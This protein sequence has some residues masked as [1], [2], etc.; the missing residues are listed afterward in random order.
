MKIHP[1]GRVLFLASLI[2]SFLPLHALIPVESP[3]LSVDEK[4]YGIRT[5]NGH[6]ESIQELNVRIVS[7]THSDHPFVVECFFLK[8]GKTGHPPLVDDTV[9]FEVTDPHATFEIQAKPIGLATTASTTTSK[10][11]GKSSM[12]KPK[13]LE[14]PREGWIIRLLQNDCVLRQH[15]SSHAVENLVKEDPELLS[16]ASASRKARHLDAD[17]LRKK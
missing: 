13:S 16:R 12:G 10:K 3:S 2:A 7:H 6:R 15:C 9:I 4:A 14:V 1:L 11:R 17:D 8:R 5:D